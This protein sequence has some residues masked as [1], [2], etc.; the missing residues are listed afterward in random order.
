MHPDLPEQLLRIVSD[1][2]SPKITSKDQIDKVLNDPKNFPIPL[3]VYADF[4]KSESARRGADNAKE[5]AKKKAKEEAKKG[6]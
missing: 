3:Q 6:K 1:K 5:L 4:M 2:L